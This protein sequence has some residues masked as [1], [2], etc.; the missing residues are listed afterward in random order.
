MLLELAQGGDARAL[1]RLC[2]RHFPAAPLGLGPL[3]R[4]ARDLAET[5]DIVLSAMVSALRRLPDF[6]PRHEGALQGYFRQAVLNQIRDHVRR[7]RRRPLALPLSGEEAGGGA[8]PLEEA[9]GRETVERYEAAL[10][11]LHD[12]ERES[13][14]LRIELGLGYREIAAALGRPTADA[15]RMA[16][17]RALVRLAEEMGDD[18]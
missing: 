5:D 15:A 17:A 3:P 7:V 8:S 2:A 13:I 9:I 4:F 18:G 12:E 10:A 16:V 14:H 11:R 1:D 6:Q